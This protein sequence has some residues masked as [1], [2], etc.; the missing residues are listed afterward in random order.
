MAASRDTHT[1]FMADF[2]WLDNDEECIAQWRWQTIQ[3]ASETKGKVKAVFHSFSLSLQPEETILL[4]FAH[5]RIS[6]IIIYDVQI[7]EAGSKRSV[8]SGRVCLMWN[9]TVGA[10]ERA[11]RKPLFNFEDI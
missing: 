10:S 11:Q 5:L 1:I 8:S 7:L 2:R 3:N 6:L 4:D 9:G